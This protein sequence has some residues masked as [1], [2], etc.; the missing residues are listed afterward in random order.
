[1]NRFA[2]LRALAATLPP[3]KYT[4]PAAPVNAKRM[5]A[6]KGPFGKCCLCGEPSNRFVCAHCAPHTRSL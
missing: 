6:P 4:L 3:S 2:D 1:M 5:P